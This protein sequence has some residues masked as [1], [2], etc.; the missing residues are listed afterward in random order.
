MIV[1]DQ[2]SRTG[3]DR[4]DGFI[5]EMKA[6]YPNIQIIGPQYG[7]GDQLKSTD[8]AKAMITANPDIKGFFGA[9]EGSA[10]GVINAVK[11]LKKEGAIKVV[12]YDS[13]KAQIDAINSG[14]M[15]GAIT[16][17]PVGIGEQCVDA[18]VKAINGR[19][20]A[21]ERST[22]ASTGTT[23]PT[24]TTR[25]SRPSSTSRTPLGSPPG[26]TGGAC[27]I[28]AAAPPSSLVARCEDL[29]MDELLVEMT[30]ITKEFPGVRAL[31]DA[32][33]ELRP[34]EVHALV[35]E[36]G[37][38]KSTLM[39][40]LAGVYQ[41]DGGEIR[42]K[43]APVQIANPRTA[44]DLGISM[45][46]QELNL[47]P[48]LTVAQNVFMGREPRGRLAIPAR[49]QAAQRADAGADRPP[50]S[51][52]RPEGPRRRPQDR[53]AADGRDRE[54]AVVRRLRP[55]HGRADR[56]ADR[57]RDRRAVPDHPRPARAG[58]RGRPHLAPARG[59]Q[60]DL[61]PG[62][63]H[64]RRA[65]HRHVETAEATSRRSST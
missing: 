8:L 46:H 53:P 16:Q 62:D 50:P 38:G 15:M 24:S 20:P 56:G 35:G 18:A 51:A 23:R 21:Q 47:M 49:R 25:R 45:I 2:T 32:E 7:A 28:L 14:L 11:E 30:G 63:G 40:I 33:F 4:R 29:R 26:T 58:R 12:G 60:A 10:I 64:A 44:L 41:P 17:N 61:G 55:D 1:H 9:N 36:N 22:P 34:G 54:G 5:N 42:Y 48:H 27:R 65:L 31:V 59:A 6:K 39:K 57:H 37:A 52:A 19:D 13:G 43:G 3:I